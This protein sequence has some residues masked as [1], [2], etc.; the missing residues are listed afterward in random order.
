[1]RAVLRSWAGEGP[2]PE[3][4]AYLDEAIPG[5]RWEAKYAGSDN[6]TGCPV[7][8]YRANR[9]AGTLEMLSGLLEARD[10]AKEEGLSLLV[11]D[12]YRPCRAVAD[13]M[14]WAAAPEDG[15]TRAAHYPRLT[16]NLLFKEGY[17]AEKSGHSRGSTVDLTLADAQGRPLDMGGIFDLMDERSH[18]GSPDATPGQKENRS[19]LLHI[20][21]RAGFLPYENEWWHYRLD[22]E[23]YPNEYFDFVI[24]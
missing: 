6:F 14:R 2:L 22:G 10:A 9:V 20:M 23:P 5:V 18:H 7:D 1:M 3:G 8:G 4:F 19:R 13:F 21:Q 17:I 11:W 12:A 15:K 24:G 16:K